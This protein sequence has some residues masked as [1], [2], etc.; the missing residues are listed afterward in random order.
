[1]KAKHFVIKVNATIVI[2]F[3]VRIPALR[4]L[5]VMKVITL[6]MAS[7]YLVLHKSQIVLT[8]RCLIL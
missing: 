1:M 3:Y 8:V 4:V 2:A 7:V 5:Y 6:P